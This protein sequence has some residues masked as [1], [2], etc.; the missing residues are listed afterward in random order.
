ME[1]AYLPSIKRCVIIV[2]LS[3]L[4]SHFWNSRVNLIWPIITAATWALINL[5]LQ[6]KCQSKLPGIAVGYLTQ[7]CY[8][9][10][11]KSALMISRVFCDYIT[12]T[13]GIQKSLRFSAI[14]R[15]EWIPDIWRFVQ[16]KYSNAP[17]FQ[18]DWINKN[19]SCNV[20]FLKVILVNYLLRHQ[21]TSPIDKRRKLVKRKY[22]VYR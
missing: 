6:R 1:T 17:T 4:R 15:R 12:H 10:S 18:V 2:A 5:N 22:H 3:R 21:I 9:N 8:L 20:T 13:Y 16:K 19:F 11:C 7:R 14:F